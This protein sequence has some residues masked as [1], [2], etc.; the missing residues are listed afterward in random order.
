MR[1]AMR[2]E[3]SYLEGGP[4]IWMLPLYLHVNQK[5]D[6]DDDMKVPGYFLVLLCFIEIPVLHANSVDPDQTPHSVASDLGLH[7]LPINLFRVS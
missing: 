7:R 3:A 6:Y 1:S 4:L 5:S 2:A